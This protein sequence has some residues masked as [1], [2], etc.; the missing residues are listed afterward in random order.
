MAFQNKTLLCMECGIEFEFTAEQ[1]EQ[2]LERGY[3]KEPKRCTPCREKHRAE[4]PPPERRPPRGNE[5]QGPPTSGPREFF[6]TV[7]S[8]C[9]KPTQ[10]P[11][12]PAPG[13]P[14]Y[15]RD[16]FLARRQAAP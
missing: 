2:F 6:A 16:C 15:C 1:Q 14:V 7:C 12:K 9:N 5:R 11:F 10:V 8:Q 13:R 3:T 4:R